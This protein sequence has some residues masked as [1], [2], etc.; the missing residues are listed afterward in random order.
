MPTDD[1]STPEPQELNYPETLRLTLASAD[2][3]FESALDAASATDESGQTD[4]VVSFNSIDGLRQ[5][6]TDR[7]LELVRSL[8]GDPAESI[9]AL[10]DRLDR[11]Y[12]AVHD[13]VEVLADHGIVKFRE[14]DQSRGPFVPYERIEFDVTISAPATGDDTETV[15]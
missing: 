11:T 12:S 8:M 5:L 9:T 2:E 7:R 4:A 6:L 10:A 1:T 14:S 3:A 15:A 13:D